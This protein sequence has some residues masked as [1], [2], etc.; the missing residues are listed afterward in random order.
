MQKS[1]F[2]KTVV[3][4]LV[5]IIVSGCL[6]LI[7][8]CVEVPTDFTADL[9]GLECVSPPPV[10][11]A[12]SAKWEMGCPFLYEVRDSTGAVIDTALFIPGL[13]PVR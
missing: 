13:I 1:R 2:T 9:E 10:V 8:A 4:L 5:A 12:D 6:A 7:I 3:T 11:P